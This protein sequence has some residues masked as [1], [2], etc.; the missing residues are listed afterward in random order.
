[1]N[2]LRCASTMDGHRCQGLRWHG[3]RHHWQK[4]GYGHYWSTDTTKR[5]TYE[6][7]APWITWTWLATDRETRFTG[8]MRMRL[9]CCIC[10]QTEIVRP[11][12]PRFGPVPEPEGG[13]HP[14]RHKAIERHSHPGQR[15]PV[16]WALPFRNTAAWWDGVPLS[17]FENVVRTAMM[18]E[19]E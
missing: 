8:R 14:E 19:D 13:I 7:N 3:H 10:G 18:E 4:A 1:M 11:R 9:T 12:I 5:E 6:I 16:D 17:A 15:D 2:P